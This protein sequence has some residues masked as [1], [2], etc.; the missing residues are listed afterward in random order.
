MRWSRA[1][2]VLLIA[3][4]A[5]LAPLAWAAWGG[6]RL[7]GPGV[8]WIAALDLAGGPERAA[9]VL[10]SW[11]RAGVLEAATG[12]VEWGLALAV[13]AALVLGLSA[14]AAAREAPP[15][16]DAAGL[17]ASVLA[18]AGGACAYGEKV[19]LLA[20]LESSGR[21]GAAAAAVLCR[22]A[23]ALLGAALALAVAV[24]AA[25]VLRRRAP[26][27]ALGWSMEGAEAQPLPCDLVMKGGITSGVVYPGAVFALARRYRF[28][29]IGGSSAGAIAAALTAAAEFRRQRTGKLDGFLALRDTTAGL[30]APGRLFGLFQPAPAC[31][32]LFDVLAA[33]LRPGSWPARLAWAAWAAVA[34][35]PGGL[36]AGLLL[37]VAGAV[38]AFRALG[39]SGAAWLSASSALLAAVL[40][41][42]AL[43]GAMAWRAFRA[44]PREGFGLCPGP[45][46]P[47]AA[48]PGLSDWLAERIDAIA[49]GGG[50]PAGEP[51]TLG[52]LWCAELP[53]SEAPAAVAGRAADPA[54]RRIQ[55]EALTTCL[56]LGRP[57]RIPFERVRLWFR[58][59]ELRRV[60]PD[61]VV[62]FM[63]ARGRLVPHSPRLPPLPPGVV[64]LPPAQ[65]LPLAFVARMSLSFPVLLAAPC[66]VGYRFPAKAP[67][68]RVRALTEEE[69]AAP[70]VEEPAGRYGALRFSDGGI[71]S[72]FP[73]HFFDQP[74]PRWPTF[75]LDLGARAPGGERVRIVHR[76]GQGI[77]APWIDVRGLAGF[78]SAV[79]ESLHA[80]MDNL[81]KRA[82]GYR[83]RIVRVD[84][85]P[86]E[87][88]LNLRMPPDRILRIAGYGLQAGEALG[89]WFDPRPAPPSAPG[90][91]A[92]GDMPS[93]GGWAWNNHRWVR[94]RSTLALLEKAL[95]A[96]ARGLPPPPFTRPYDDMIHERS[97]PPPS[98]PYPGRALEDA[99]GALA[100]ALAAAPLEPPP[101]LST[102]APRPEPELRIVPRV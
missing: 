2:D 96:F 44:L 99:A 14:V 92:A 55:L 23:L 47:G 17:A 80:W 56:T 15:G 57:W 54:L 81:Q 87:G 50:A 79:F 62:A 64:A 63:E 7:G 69:A 26:E 21:A 85:D 13:C 27:P 18:L 4:A 22:L 71:S 100:A 58:P 33:A 83:D 89:A 48:R 6:G 94:F 31:A 77:L 67:A 78:G 53:S 86:E 76:N 66:L 68:A 10:E 34:S 35:F 16:W 3:A 43:A 24:V 90:D 82:P 42:A 45:T 70:D 72:N 74:I 11:R 88:G 52:D 40:V 20:V 95:G 73:I 84:L 51:L 93:S 59:E 46:V 101:G 41:P 29:S 5:A 61:R 98:Y 38:A 91:A 8:P 49:A 39:P 36:A 60:L 9:Q 30:A 32:G 25:R 37:P 19:A 102:D 1:G 12:A 65:D 28:A 75:G 97:G